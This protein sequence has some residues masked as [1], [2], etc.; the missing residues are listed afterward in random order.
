MI[1]ARLW[2]LNLL[3]LLPLVILALTIQ[4]R[5]KKKAM[6]QFADAALLERLT[7]RDQGRRRF[8]KGILLLCSL[9]LLFF[10]LAGPRWGSSYQEVSQK[11]VDIVILVD[12]SPS[13]MV[14]DIKTTRL[15]RARR[16]IID[17]L[18]VV[19]G[20][21][22]GLVA[23]S[24]A[25][26]IQCPLT[27]D[28]G[29]LQLFLNALEPG[30][31]P[32]SGTDLGAAID[33][34]L[35]AFDFKSETD[36]VMLL[37]TDGEDN[38]RRGVEAAR[39]ADERNV[40]IFV[41]GIG[42]LSG[43]PIPDEE[44]KGGFKKDKEGKLVLSKLNEEALKTIAV[45]SG[46]RYVRS[47]AGDLDLDII[48]FDG[49]KS[50]TQAQTL[51][52]GKIKIYDERFPLFVLAAL[53]LLLLEGFIDDK[54]MVT[55]R[56]S[57]T[58]F[59]VILPTIFVLIGSQP[60]S[61]AFAGEGPD[62]LY[63][64]GRFAEA[65][66]AYAQSD[67]DHPKDVRYRYNRGC[68]AY[69]NS[70]YKGAMAAFSS[71]LRRIQDDQ[72]RFKAAYNLG[73]TAY[74]LN[75]FDLAIAHYR[76]ALL[77]NP[78]S[79][80]ARHNLELAVR[81]RE[82]QKKDQAEKSETK[83]KQENQKGHRPENQQQSDDKNEKK[84][85]S[86][87]EAKQDLKQTPEKKSEQ[88]PDPKQGETDKGES[89]K[90]SGEDRNSDDLSGELKAL[91]ELPR[92]DKKNVRP[93]NDEGG[94]SVDKRRAEALLDNIKEDPSRLLRFLIPEEKRHGVSSGKDW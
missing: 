7:A 28:Y 31:I 67:M 38:E 93:S 83:H 14:Q 54:K 81:A 25:A 91:K 51:K 92:N 43:G 17:F 23:F 64:Q 58:G 41:F 87:K 6:D 52:S 55:G 40:K 29:A 33:T 47:V 70:D 46:G 24:G 57:A 15:E 80:D 20:D 72:I 56:F 30:L 39:R 44:G 10:A 37:I 48:Y 74:K 60:F 89:E 63:K 59:I 32:V 82:K 66:K 78:T 49:I 50:V 53:L 9:G 65:E 68:S 13:M 76:Q 8:L 75:D 84:P 1:L 77:Y 11:G 26:F 88:K 42:E 69:Q 18:R 90:H 3:W 34:G 94:A 21:R 22:V 16:E 79:E 61:T 86:D 45:Y 12:V 4:N 2:V 85:S 5:K 71:V 73:N 35:S 27:L 62:Q 36:K 19:E